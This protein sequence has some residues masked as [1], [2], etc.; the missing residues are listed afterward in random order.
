VPVLGPQE[1]AR[2]ALQFLI[3]SLEDLE[4]KAMEVG[5]DFFRSRSFLLRNAISEPILA[6]Y[7]WPL[8]AP[9]PSHRPYFKYILAG[10]G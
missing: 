1:L 4:Q 10:F 2:E 7:M 3:Y 8:L 9:K 6:M 5:G